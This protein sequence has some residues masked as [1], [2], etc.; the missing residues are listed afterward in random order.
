MPR[1]VMKSM[2]SDLMPCCGE[3]RDE[4]DDFDLRYVVGIKLRFVTIL[5]SIL[6]KTQLAPGIQWVLE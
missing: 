3:C 1:C 6:E 2:I 4:I 5:E